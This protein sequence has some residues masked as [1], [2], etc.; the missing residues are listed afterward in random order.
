M[1]TVGREAV[2]AS[3]LPEHEAIRLL[4]AASGLSRVQILTGHEIDAATERSFD[5][6]VRRRLAGEPLQYIEGAVRFGP[7]RVTI[8]DRVLIP[9]PETEE[10]FEL[11]R[12]M[13]E[14]PDVIVDLCTGSGVLAVAL[15]SAYPDADV[16]A[17]DIDEN[18]I[19]VARANAAANDVSVAF[20]VGDLFA[21]LPGGIEGC[22]DLL[23]ANPPYLTDADYTDVDQ[24]VR[25]EP[26]SA[27]VSGPTGLEVIERIGAMA[28]L[29]LRPGG[30]VA[31]EVS[32]FSAEAAR[33]AFVRLDTRVE[34]D[35]LGKPR[36]VVGATRVE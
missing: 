1:T 21:P 36:F 14:S 31:C 27:L 3:G 23:V 2:A 29:W 17:T 12:S 34:T 20:G 22:I 19:A 16:H 32:E 33:A 35:F 11:A 9:R 25:R 10:L 18:A 5:A 6:F 15:A 4:E 24:D 13:V 7:V 28:H 26:K 8:D 30:V